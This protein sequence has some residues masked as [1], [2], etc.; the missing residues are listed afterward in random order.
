[1]AATQAKTK[2]KAK[3]K[4]KPKVKVAE[5]AAKIVPMGAVALR[6]LTLQNVLSFGAEAKVE[7]GPLNVLIGPNGCG[8]SNLLDVVALLKAA[9]TTDLSGEFRGGAENW[10]WNGANN[11][12][13]TISIVS[14]WLKGIQY[15]HSM[16]IRAREGKYSISNSEN[17]LYVNPVLASI[18]DSTGTRIERA[19]K[20]PFYAFTGKMREETATGF[21]FLI[22]SRPFISPTKML[23]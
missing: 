6:S 16:D 8:K 22:L 15:A 12:A 5:G 19:D 7:L 14:L 2:A 1:M 17:I 3:A 23:C 13:D 10:V 9:A 4:A 21:P 11:D 18:G 20:E